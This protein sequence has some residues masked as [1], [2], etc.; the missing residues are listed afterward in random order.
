M[1][2]DIQQQNVSS[3]P[4]FLQAHCWQ[5]IYIVCAVLSSSFKGEEIVF[6]QEATKPYSDLT[7]SGI[8][9]VEMEILPHTEE[10]IDGGP[11]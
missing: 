8:M 10:L 1:P 4:P 7:L 6:N 3:L 2:Q 5:V 11:W 9:W